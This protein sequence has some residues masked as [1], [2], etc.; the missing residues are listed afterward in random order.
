MTHSLESPGL[1]SAA[2]T[3][4]AA[5]HIVALPLK[6]QFCILLPTYGRAHYVHMTSIL[7]DCVGAL[8]SPYRT[9]MMTLPVAIIILAL[10]MCIIP[11]T[12]LAFTTPSLVVQQ[13]HMRI[14]WD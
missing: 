4:A 3:S 13:D 14:P 2:C 9:I 7:I 8:H 1:V 11:C 6:E 10:G 12:W 5:H